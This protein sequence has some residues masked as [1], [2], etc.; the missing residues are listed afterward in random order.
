VS[1][2]LG[3]ALLEGLVDAGL[4]EMVGRAI[5]ARVQ[6][7][8]MDR[9]AGQGLD[10]VARQAGRRRVGERD[11]AFDVESVDAVTDGV[12]DRL[13]GCLQLTVALGQLAAQSR[14]GQVRLDPGD[15]LFGLKWLGDVVDGAE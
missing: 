10:R 2:L 9:L 15:D 7:E 3:D 6:V 12:E 11:A 13:V 8:F 1:L 14:D 4:D 5:P